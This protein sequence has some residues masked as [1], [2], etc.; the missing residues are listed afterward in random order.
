MSH[1]WY[2]RYTP[3]SFSIEYTGCPGPRSQGTP[4]RRIH[5]TASVSPTPRSVGRG[6]R[7]SAR[8]LVPERRYRP[9]LV[10]ASSG[11]TSY[12]SISLSASVPVMASLSAPL[13]AGAGDS[14]RRKAEHKG[15][16][17]DSHSALFLRIV[18]DV[19]EPS[20]HRILPRAEM[21]A[22]IV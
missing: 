20:F 19:H 22:E 2:T 16:R 15:E 5:R 11:E 3:G 7:V 13:P 18:H 10:V 4:Q 14:V 12:R 9:E 17:D 1:P 8:L 21:C 6:R